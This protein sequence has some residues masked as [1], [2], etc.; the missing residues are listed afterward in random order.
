MNKILLERFP[1]ENDPILMARK[2]GGVPLIGY[3]YTPEPRQMDWACDG[4]LLSVTIRGPW[5][6]D[7]ADMETALEVLLG[8]LRSRELRPVMDEVVVELVSS[9]MD[10]S[11]RF[12]GVQVERDVIESL[13]REAGFREPSVF[14]TYDYGYAPPLWKMPSLVAPQSL[15]VEDE[16]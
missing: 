8:D 14:E 5:T 2:T 10:E 7:A 6:L 11:A 15:T 12:N 13:V 1:A 3:L 9:L 4:R 16:D